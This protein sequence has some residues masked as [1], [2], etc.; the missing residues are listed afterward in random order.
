MRTLRNRGRGCRA[1]N[2]G[3]R[4]VAWANVAVRAIAWMLIVVISVAWICSL[5]WLFYE[6][7]G[8][9]AG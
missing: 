5:A 3:A 8:A 7:W 4:P 9:L 2:G 6:L 1:G